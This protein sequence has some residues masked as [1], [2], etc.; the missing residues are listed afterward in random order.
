[1]FS[2]ER[3]PYRKLKRAI[4]KKTGHKQ[5]VPFQCLNG[6]RFYGYEMNFHFIFG[7]FIGHK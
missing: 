5:H 7:V 1:M 6:F 2:I 4:G 3:L